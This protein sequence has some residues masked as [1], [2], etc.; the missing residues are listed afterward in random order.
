MVWLF[1]KRHLR[2]A[3]A[4]ALVWWLHLSDSGKLTA[5]LNAK[6]DV[7]MQTVGPRRLL[8]RFATGLLAI[9][10]GLFMNQPVTTAFN[11]RMNPE[12]SVKSMFAGAIWLLLVAFFLH[13][14]PSYAADP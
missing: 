1:E 8:A 4:A 13:P 6:L 7:L 10:H 9:A 12:I 14:I 3:Q 11:A 5:L 2:R